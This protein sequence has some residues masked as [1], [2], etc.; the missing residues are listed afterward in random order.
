MTLGLWL[1]AWGLFCARAV[2]QILVQDAAPE[3]LID[4]CPDYS[5]YSAAPQ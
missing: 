3:R 5:K 4:A 2:G 1:A